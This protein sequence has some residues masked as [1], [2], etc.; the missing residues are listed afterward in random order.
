MASF[1]DES[2]RAVIVRLDK[3]VGLVDLLIKELVEFKNKARTKKEENLLS[4]TAVNSYIVGIG[5]NTYIDE[6]KGRVDFLKFLLS[7]Y[8][9]Y[10]MC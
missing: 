3:E 8:P 2:K 10:G 1:Y 5:R 7:L 9:G 6:V 4:S